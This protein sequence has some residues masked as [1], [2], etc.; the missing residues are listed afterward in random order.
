MY[1]QYLCGGCMKGV[2]STLQILIILL[3]FALA[4]LVW[5]SGAWQDVLSLLGIANQQLTVR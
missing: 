1:K 5:L 3:V 4:L 2:L